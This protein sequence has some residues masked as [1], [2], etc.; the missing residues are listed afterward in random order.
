MQAVGDG[1]GL[2]GDPTEVA[3]VRGGGRGRRCAPPRPTA[4]APRRRLFHFD[5]A[6]RLMTT[7]D[8]RDGGLAATVKGAPEDVLRAASRSRRRRARCR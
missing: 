5:P 6:L 7:V 2:A 4:T 8:A 1:G 3:L